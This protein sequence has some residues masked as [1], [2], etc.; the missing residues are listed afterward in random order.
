MRTANILGGYSLGE[1]DVLRKAVGKKDAE[2]IKKELNRFI[3]RAVERGVA[4]RIAEALGDQIAAVGRYGFVKAHSSAFSLVSYHTAWLK[5]HYP[6]EF[7]A[8]MLSA[9]LEKTDDV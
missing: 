9:V 7:M 5:A 1:S 8:A 3:T 2:L 6:A 4:P